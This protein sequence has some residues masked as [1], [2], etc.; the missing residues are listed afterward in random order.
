MLPVESFIP[1]LQPTCSRGN[2]PIRLRIFLQML[3]EMETLLQACLPFSEEN[4][5]QEN[6]PEATFQRD[7]R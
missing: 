2:L 5:C 4:Q 1:L 6:T 3:G 7:G